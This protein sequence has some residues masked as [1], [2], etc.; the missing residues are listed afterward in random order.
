MKRPFD[1]LD[2]LSDVIERE[3]GAQASEVV[4]QNLEASTCATRLFTGEA[5]THGF[6]DDLAERLARS[7]NLRFHLGCHVLVQRQ[8]RSHISMLGNRH[9]DVKIGLV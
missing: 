3:T 2:E 8:R 9:H 6:V 1:L 4:R 7:A 5:S